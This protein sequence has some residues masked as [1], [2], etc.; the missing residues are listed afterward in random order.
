MATLCRHC[1][2]VFK[3][4]I[5]FSQSSGFFVIPVYLLQL[6]LCYKNFLLYSLWQM[7]WNIWTG[8]SP[9]CWRGQRHLWLQR[10]PK[11]WRSH[12]QGKEGR[13]VVGSR[14][15]IRNG[16]LAMCSRAVKTTAAA[17]RLRRPPVVAPAAA[18]QVATVD[19]TI[20]CFSCVHGSR[21]GT[22]IWFESSILWYTYQINGLEFL[23]VHS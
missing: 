10:R 23:Q 17:V 7:K 12:K 3:W 15:N 11:R 22:Q 16:N 9:F 1:S 19:L 6:V 8:R 18:L 2:T 4:L 14:Y 21:L 13:E 20:M 5:S